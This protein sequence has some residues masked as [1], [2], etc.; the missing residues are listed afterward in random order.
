MEQITLASRYQV[1]EPL[2][3]GGFSC[4]FKAKDYHLPGEP[5]CVVKQLKPQFKDPK[6]LETAQRLFNGEAEILYRLGNHELIPRLLAHFEQDGEFYLVQ[7]FIEGQPLN[8]ELTPGKQFSESETRQLLQDIL[9]VLVFVHAQGVIHRDLKPANLIRRSQDRKIVVIDF[10]AFKAVSKACSNSSQQ[11]NITIAVGSPGYMPS[12]QSM[13]KP[14]FSS[15]IY[16]VGMIALQALTGLPCV[17]LR[18]NVWGEYTCLEHKEKITISP[19]L[20]SIIDKMVC[21]DYRYRYQ[22][23][24]EALQALVSFQEA[25]SI[26]PENEP[27]LPP[28]I[29][30]QAAYVTSDNSTIPTPTPSPVSNLEP[31]EGQVRLGSPFYVERPPTETDCYEEIVKPGSL[32]RIKA[33]RQMGKTS[34]MSRILEHARQN[35]QE[36]LSLN[37][38]SIDTHLLSNLDS[39]LQ[40][41][42]ANISDELDLD[43][44]LEKYW[45]GV[46]GSKKKCSKYLRKYLLKNLDSPLTLGLDEVDQVFQ[47]PEIATDFFGLLRTWHENGKNEPTWQKLRLIIVHSKE[48]YIPLNINQS[49]FNVG[50]S[51]ELPEW[52]FQQV[53]TSAQQH[54]LNWTE[55]EINDLMAM[56]GGHPYLVRRAFY[57]IAKG[58]MSLKQLL[59]SAPTEGGTYGDYLRRHLINL[60]ENPELLAA[61]KEVLATDSPVK[62]GTVESF[63]L[64]SMGLVKFQGNEVMP[65]CNLY[66]LYFQERL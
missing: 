65:L 53:K 28:T 52:N 15:D 31:P 43:D 58:R 27:T 66:R 45:Q 17:K 22:N 44:Q 60:K 12:E 4:T 5:I 38:Q 64:Q 35:G 59:Q 18:R 7:D 46:L 9:E 40:W 6:D 49:P 61:I 56:V 24:K 2:G 47:H 34:L 19:H 10:G 51:I 25:T 20:G 63:K 36:T 14:Q 16:A 11:T 21:Y 54:G 30:H 26:P 1:L 23:A 48:V 57:Q 33:P 37:F 41:F 42:C 32:I 8:Q 62:I 55:A 50:L 29:P 13:G 39:F 3:R